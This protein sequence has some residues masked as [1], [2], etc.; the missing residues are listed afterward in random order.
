MRGS[1]WYQEPRL[2]YVGR[3]P[4]AGRIEV[5]LASYHAKAKRFPHHVFVYRAGVSEGEFAAVLEH[6]RNAFIDAFDSLRSK[7]GSAFVRPRLTIIVVQE[8]SSYRMV[9]TAPVAKKWREQ[10][11][12]AAASAKKPSPSGSPVK[13]F[14]ANVRPGTCVDGRIMH[15]TLTEFLLVGHRAIKGTARPIRCSVVWDDP[16]AVGGAGAR[17]SLEELENVTNALCYAHGIVC[18][19][20][21]LP[22]PL[23]V[24]LGVFGGQTESATRG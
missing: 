5:A 19:P 7:H 17:V 15:P 11:E 22:A 14:N 9:P 20:V 2:T 6:E 13:A 3:P 4:L 18:S 16:G 1:Y 23:Y 8:H 10:E 12:K 21:S 24:S